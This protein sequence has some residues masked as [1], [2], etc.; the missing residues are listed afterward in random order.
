MDDISTEE[1]SDISQDNTD[2]QKDLLSPSKREGELLSQI[3][4]LEDKLDLL[5]M[6]G[7]DKVNASNDSRTLKSEYSNQQNRARNAARVDEGLIAG[8]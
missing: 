4:D 2:S 6:V 5:G 8:A 1:L 7:N 3:A